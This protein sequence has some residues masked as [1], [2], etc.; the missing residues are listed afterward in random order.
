MKQNLR[1]GDSYAL[2]ATNHTKH[3]R[4]QSDHRPPHIYIN[5]QSPLRLRSSSAVSPLRLDTRSVPE[6]CLTRTCSAISS[7]LLRSF[8]ACSPLLLRCFSAAPPLKKRRR[9]GKQVDNKGKT[10]S[11]DTHQVR[12]R[13]D[14]DN[15][16]QRNINRAE[17]DNPNGQSPRDEPRLALPQIPPSLTLPS[18]PIRVS[19]AYTSV[20]VPANGIL[21]K[22]W[23]LCSGIKAYKEGHGTWWGRLRKSLLCVQT[24]AQ[25]LA[26]PGRG[27]AIGVLLLV[28][29]LSVATINAQARY[30]RASDAIIEGTVMTSVSNLPLEGAKVCIME[31]GQCA[32]ANRHGYF[33]LPASQADGTLTVSFNGYETVEIPYEGGALKRGR[34]TIRLKKDNASIPPLA[35]G[36]TIPGQLWDM[37]LSVINEP[38]GRTEVTLGEYRDSSLIVLDFWA[39]WCAPCVKS[40]QKWQEATEKYAH[41]GLKVLTVNVGFF[42][43]TLSFMD[44]RSWTLPAVVGEN[45]HLLNSYFFDRYQVGGVVWI[46]DGCI[47]A[48]SYENGENMEKLP[49]LLE[50]RPVVLHSTSMNTHQKP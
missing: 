37:A 23:R 17:A 31:T 21:A 5:E 10:S 39:T 4:K 41:N 27:R 33:A 14:E 1:L 11:V 3:K 20:K 26:L 38:T 16:L 32:T 40:V 7:V 18:G 29:F 2:S 6:P 25:A 43:R 8:S 42:D 28:F 19:P 34:T 49:L 46:K 12:S 22:V 9:N 36:D 44:E 45:T 15:D 35:V 48:I 24:H 47:A 13:Y 30:S 50:G